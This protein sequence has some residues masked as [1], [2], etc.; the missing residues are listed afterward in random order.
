[1]DGQLRD[2]FA[3]FETQRIIFI[4]DSCLAG[5]M[6][7]L[8]APGR[9]INMACSESGVSYEDDSWQNG[10]LLISSLTK[11]CWRAKLTNTII[12]QMLQM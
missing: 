9:V 5:G 1:M 4:F 10:Q 3:G 11:E 8:Q 12:F 7:D 6:T 2:W